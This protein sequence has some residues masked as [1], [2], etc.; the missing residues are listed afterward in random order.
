MAHGT[1]Y[2]CLKSRYTNGTIRQTGRNAKWLS[3]QIS[4]SH[5]Q[6][7][8][9][10]VIA[11]YKLEDISSKK[12]EKHEQHLHHVVTTHLGPAYHHMDQRKIRQSQSNSWTD[13]VQKTTQCGILRLTW[14]TQHDKAYTHGNGVQII[15][16]KSPW[17]HRLTLLCSFAPFQKQNNVSFLKFHNKNT[18][19]RK[20]GQKKLGVPTELPVGEK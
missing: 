16:I 11:L 2:K 14:Q 1:Y 8:P 4:G 13:T 20:I 10:H 5:W 7:N 9:F 3:R 17:E 19:F 15:L 18:T 6:Y 12:R